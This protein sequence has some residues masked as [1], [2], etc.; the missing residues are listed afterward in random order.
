MPIIA[1]HLRHIRLLELLDLRI[2]QL[3]MDSGNGLIDPLLAAQTNDRIHLALAQ[4]PGRRHGRHG[5]ALGPGDL[6]DA[7]DDLLVRRGLAAAEDGLEEPV[8]RLAVRGAIAPGSREDAACYWG[9]LAR[10]KI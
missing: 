4:T 9:P 3:D 2:R 8:R 10:G 1:N 6:L 5:H 7:V